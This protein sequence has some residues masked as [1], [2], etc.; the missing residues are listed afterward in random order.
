MMC[1]FNDL[2]LSMKPVLG[3]HLKYEVYEMLSDICNGHTR[4]NCLEIVVRSSKVSSCVGAARKV[5]PN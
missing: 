1:T 5:S 3:Q 2:F 4:Q